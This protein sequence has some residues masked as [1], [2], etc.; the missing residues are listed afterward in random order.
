[1]SEHI[2]AAVAPEAYQEEQGSSMLSLLVA[3]SARKKFILGM[4]L[5]AA[6]ATAGLSLLVPNVYRASARL[7][8]PQQAQSGAMGMLA[9][10]GGAAGLAGGL[11]G[12]K[13]PNELYV[14]MLKSRTVADQLLD[15]HGLMKVYDTGS[16]EKARLKLAADS[17]ISAGKDGLITIAVDSTDPKLAAGVANSYVALLIKL[18]GVLA[19]TEAGQRRLFFEKQ[20]EESKN[21]L[22]EAE[23]NF[24]S[25]LDTSGVISVDADSRAIVETV[26]RMRAQVSAK[27]VQLGSMHAFLTPSNPQY[28]R[29]QEELASLRAELAR[30]ENGRPGAAAPLTE[31]SAGLGNIKIL[32]DVKYY[33]M[34]YELL[35]KQYEVARLDEARDSSVIQIL[36]S[37]IEPEQKVKPARA[38]MVVLASVLA[39]FLACV[40]AVA[41]ELKKKLESSP[42]HAAQLAQLKR[43]LRLR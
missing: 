43:N 9:Q 13:S 20:L 33:Q 41:L 35:A 28:Q 17:A 37:A 32:R 38:V 31:R 7:L 30:L 3:I 34:L 26:A 8:P 5:A 22:A 14:G 4:T 6:V 10:L 24:K 23:A 2:S 16:R 11:A 18:T 25:G 29:V 1:M 42:E 15:Q 40:I 19:V 21:K 36:D 27:E 39:F 12:I